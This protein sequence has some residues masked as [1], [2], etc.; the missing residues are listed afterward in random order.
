MSRIDSSNLSKFVATTT[1]FVAGLV[2]S[3][4]FMAVGAFFLQLY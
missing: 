4:P 3:A 2:L 1:V